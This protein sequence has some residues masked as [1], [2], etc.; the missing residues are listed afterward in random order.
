[1]RMDAG[2]GDAGRNW[3]RIRLKFVVREVMGII[4]LAV[5]LFHGGNKD[6]TTWKE[7]C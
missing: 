2:G 6:R 7:Y 5:R 1:M 3:W 4:Y